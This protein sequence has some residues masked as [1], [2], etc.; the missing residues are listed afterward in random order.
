VASVMGAYNRVNGESASASQRLLIDIL[1]KDWGFD[2][3]VVSDCGAIDDT[4]ER[5]GD[6]VVQ[7]YVRDPES[8]LN[9][10]IR[11]L[12][13]FERI[14]LKRSEARKVRFR[15]SPA[16]DFTHYDVDKKAYAVE[17]GEFEVQLGASSGDI[18]LTGRVRV[19]P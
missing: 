4:G 2:G 14:S 8:R 15:L 19:D 7:L 11:E 5:D 6:E 17:P 9:M 10:P 12:R 13:G 18:R 3:Y 1:R 16:K